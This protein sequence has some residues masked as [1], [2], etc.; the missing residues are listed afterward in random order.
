M[1]LFI[2]ITLT[3]KMKDALGRVIFDMKRSGARGNYTIPDN[4]HIT[5]A[6]IGETN[7][8]QDIEEALDEVDFSPFDLKLDGFGSF[9]NL[10]WV[11]LSDQPKLVSLVKSVRTALDSADIPYDRKK[12]KAHITV[13]RKVEAT[14]PIKVSVP[15]ADLEVTCFSLMKSERIDGRMKYTEIAAWDAIQ[16]SEES[17]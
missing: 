2:A 12:F 5:L 17:R 16:E 1:R 3:K 4:L 15:D 7:R 8:V 10:Y 9:G 11:G 6:F 13:A 14:Y